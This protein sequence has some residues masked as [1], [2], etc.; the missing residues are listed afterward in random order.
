MSLVAL[1]APEMML[2]FPRVSGDEPF[3]QLHL[4]LSS[5]FSPRERG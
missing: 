4:R 2:S 5:A 3:S 1:I